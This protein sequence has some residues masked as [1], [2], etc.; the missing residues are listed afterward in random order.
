MELEEEKA[1]QN[2]FAHIASPSSIQAPYNFIAALSI[3]KFNSRMTQ[4][5][6]TGIRLGLIS[7]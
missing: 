3:T 4:D 7:D 6:L 1:P 2:K 5:D